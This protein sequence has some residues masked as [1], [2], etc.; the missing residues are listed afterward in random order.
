MTADELLRR[1]MNCVL[2]EVG[3]QSE[4]V[5][6]RR[7]WLVEFW[8]ASQV[9]LYRDEAAP[10]EMDWHA[11]VARLV[12]AYAETYDRFI[13]A[14][15][16]TSIDVLASWEVANGMWQT[17]R[18]VNEAMTGYEEAVGR[19]DRVAADG[20]ATVALGRLFAW[21]DNLRIRSYVFV[22]TGEVLTNALVKTEKSRLLD[23]LDRCRGRLSTDIERLLG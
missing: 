19:K 17:V 3:G 21:D 13:D 10:L 18:S 14:A 9:H 2:T 1:L 23:A 20:L 11:E 15:E 16:S 6:E 22:L 5:R 8:F 4:S 12:A 7:R